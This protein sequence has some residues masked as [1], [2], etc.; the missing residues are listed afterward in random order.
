MGFMRDSTI[1]FVV[2]LVL[3]ALATLLLVVGVG[4]R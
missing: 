4:I 3:G 1:F 2:A